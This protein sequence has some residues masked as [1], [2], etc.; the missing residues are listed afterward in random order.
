MAFLAR[1]LMGVTLATAPAAETPAPPASPAPASPP[2]IAD[3]SF[4]IEEAYNQERG[5]VQHI[6]SFMRVRRGEWAYTFTQEW[7]APGQR[8]QLSGTVPVLATGGERG[9][10]DLSLNYRY[11]ARD[12]GSG[13]VAVAPRLSL[14]LPTGSAR[15]GLGAGGAGLQANLPVSAARGRFALHTNLGATWTPSAEGAGGSEA[16]AWGWSAG[17]SAVWLVRPSFNLLLEVVFSRARTVVGPGATEAEDSLLVSPGVRW[18][19]NFE[20]GLQVVPGIAV[21]IGIGPS[22]GDTAI[23]FY[24]S[25][26]H[27]FRRAPGP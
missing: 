26:E 16:A 25:L 9:L 21:P 2:G 19:H 10:G 3:N 6:S 12:G 22:R 27:P 14:L 20:S 8:H 24:L 4:L 1:M 5:V 23:L 18:A 13:P 15:R 7:P 11:Q 17:Q